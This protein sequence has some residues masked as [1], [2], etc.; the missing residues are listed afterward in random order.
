MASIEAVEQCGRP[1]ILNDFS[2]FDILKTWI[3]EVEERC[4]NIATTGLGGRIAFPT[5]PFRN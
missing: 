4:L 3:L 5:I 1:R 2:F